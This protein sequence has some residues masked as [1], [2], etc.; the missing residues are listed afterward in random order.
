MNATDTVHHSHATAAVGRVSPMRPLHW[1]ALAWDDLMATRRASLGYGL[2]VTLGGW[3][4]FAF[5]DHPFFVAA[6]VTGFLLIGPILS[7]G[8]CEL[9]RRR[10]QK[11]FADFEASLEPLG[12]NRQGLVRFALAL[13]GIGAV[14]TLLSTLMLSSMLG[15]A[16]P[17]VDLAMWQDVVGLM[18]IQQMQAYALTGG[19]LAVLVFALSV[20][21][22]PMLVDQQAASAGAAMRQS[23]RAFSANLPAML[24]W[25]ALIAALS[26]IGFATMLVAMIVIFPLLGHASWHAYQDLARDQ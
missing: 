18:T 21:S 19:A 25:A 6:A 24:V 14:W 10:S 23:L 1:L 8:L 2:V 4:I 7:T 9:S 15:N 11:E 20:V 17:A 3:L 12:R 26:A 13:V 22:V 16:A 5:G